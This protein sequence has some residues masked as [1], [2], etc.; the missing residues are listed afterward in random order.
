[1]VD[2]SPVYQET[3][4]CGVGLGI[5]PPAV[6]RDDSRV[7][8]KLASGG[9]A[10]HVEWA[11]AQRLDACRTVHCGDRF[12]DILSAFAWSPTSPLRLPAVGN[13]LVGFGE[14]RPTT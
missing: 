10:D 6:H 13:V 7:R 5:S 2:F 8:P 9:L 4:R 1:M 14:A 3:S 11:L 12:D